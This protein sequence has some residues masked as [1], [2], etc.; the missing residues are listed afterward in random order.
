TSLIVSENPKGELPTTLAIYSR[1][2]KDVLS[3]SEG[4]ATYPS[5][6]DALGRADPALEKLRQD[7]ETAAELA[8]QVRDA[9]AAQEAARSYQ[10]NVQAVKNSRRAESKLESHQERG[11]Q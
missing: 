4:K 3:R 5:L 9:K 6:L 1:H 11:K 8:R 2:V 7:Y 10:R